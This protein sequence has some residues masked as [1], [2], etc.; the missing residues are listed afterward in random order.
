MVE[1][2]TR[3]DRKPAAWEHTSDLLSLVKAVSE[4]PDVSAREVLNYIE[5]ELEAAAG[6]GG[7]DREC[8]LC[9]DHFDVYEMEMHVMA[10]A[11]RGWIENSVAASLEGIKDE[12][13]ARDV[14]EDVRTQLEYLIETLPEEAETVEEEVLQEYAR[15]GDPE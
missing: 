13:E 14:D 7:R 12:L 15:P 9:G 4:N 3:K 10:C 1:K 2:L 5:A 6:E 11:F 8:P